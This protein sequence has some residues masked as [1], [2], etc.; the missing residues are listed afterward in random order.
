MRQELEKQ[1]L[2]LERRRDE[3]EAQRR[4][5]AAVVSQTAS[6]DV[7]DNSMGNQVT[8]EVPTNV[9]EVRWSQRD[10]CMSLGW[11]RVDGLVY[12]IKLKVGVV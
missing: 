12:V 8:I 11:G 9:L 4:R 10:G 1:R 2:E 6:M 3:I 5:D 7:P